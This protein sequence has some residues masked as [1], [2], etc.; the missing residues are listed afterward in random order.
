M[1]E[2]CTLIIDASLIWES[3]NRDLQV[4]ITVSEPEYEFHYYFCL[5]VANSV[6]TIGL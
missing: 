2:V 6:D 5:Q 3:R 1:T 4:Q